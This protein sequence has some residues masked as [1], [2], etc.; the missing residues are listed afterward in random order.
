M[1]DF[2]D[3]IDAKPLREHVESEREAFPDVYKR[4]QI[5]I[6]LG[7]L[8][9]LLEAYERMIGDKCRAC[10]SDTRKRWCHCENDE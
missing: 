8:E 7:D 5:T 10:G 3:S 1:S 6:D 4:L 9:V 2:T